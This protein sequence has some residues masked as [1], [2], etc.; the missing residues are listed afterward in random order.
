MK[1]AIAFKD[2]SILVG[3]SFGA[4]KC[5]SGELVFQTGTFNYLS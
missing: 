4:D 1:S 3:T 2:G 5:M